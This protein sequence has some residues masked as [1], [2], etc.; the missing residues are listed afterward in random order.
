M[1]DLTKIEEMLLICIWRLKEDAYGY[2]IRKY[3]SE[4][5]QKD[6]TYGNLYSALKQMV[7]KGYILKRKGIF[8]GQKHGKQRV[9]YSLT[10]SGIEALKK[11]LSIHNVLWDGISESILDRQ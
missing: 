6:F 9:F 1:T 5:I 8:E 2:R 3:I 10:P 4:I 11:N 7:D